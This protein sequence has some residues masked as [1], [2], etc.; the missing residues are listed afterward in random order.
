MQVSGS[1]CGCV[2]VALGSTGPIFLSTGDRARSPVRAETGWK[3][4]SPGFHRGAWGNH[5]KGR[6]IVVV[7]V[8]ALMTSTYVYIHKLDLY[9]HADREYIS[10]THDVTSSL[11]YR[12]VICCR[13]TQPIAYPYIHT[14]HSTINVYS[15]N[16]P[17]ISPMRPVI[18]CRLIHIPI[19]TYIPLRSMYISLTHHAYHTWGLSYVVV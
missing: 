1:G 4:H 7:M 17:C 13:L 2:R 12:S 14:T 6:S 8:M 18:G 9:T 16:T 3:D 19:H 11:H 10:L 5:V 15:A